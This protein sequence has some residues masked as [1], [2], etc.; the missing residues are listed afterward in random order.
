MRKR[1]I[2]YL[3]PQKRFQ[4]S[5]KSQNWNRISVER[6]SPII[7]SGYR[8]PFIIQGPAIR[9]SKRI[10]RTTTPIST[11]MKKVWSMRSPSCL[12][13]CLSYL[14]RRRIVDGHNKRDRGKRRRNGGN[15]TSYA[16]VSRDFIPGGKHE[17]VYI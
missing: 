16:Y 5:E 6:T 17:T 7:L 15:Q 2:L 10:I 9:I 3:N 13:P 1:R 14:R 12:I 8:G 4:R 11:L